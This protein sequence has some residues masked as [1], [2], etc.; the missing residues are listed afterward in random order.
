M[1]EGLAKTARSV[2]FKNSH[3][4]WAGYRSG[5]HAPK[6]ENTLKLS[7]RLN[8]DLYLSS[9]LQILQISQM[10]T[11][12]KTTTK[13]PRVPDLESCIFYVFCLFL[14]TAIEYRTHLLLAGLLLSISSHSL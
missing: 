5:K 8:M 3:Q 2:R 1:A 14:F 4:K 11:T 6:V 7:F 10:V 9:E 12:L 13:Q